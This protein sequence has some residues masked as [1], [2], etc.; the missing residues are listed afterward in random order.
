[1][2][3]DIFQLVLRI[4]FLLLG[5]VLIL[6]IWTH[7]VRLH[8][9]N[10]YA[11]AILRLSNWLVQPIRRLV[12]QGRWADWPALLACWLT[13]LVYMMTSWLVLTGN[14]PPLSWLMGMLPVAVLTVLEW[15]FNVVLWLT[16][17]QAILS[18]VNPMAPIMPVVQVLTAPLLDPI[19]RVLPRLGGI[20]FSPLVLLILAQIM[21]RV[22]QRLV[23]TLAGV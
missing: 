6:R 8:P 2:F 17:I 10:P 19:R 4:G 22:L 12:P 11:Q 23:Y 20:D 3:S 1:M 21:M 9:F 15:T 18:W 5:T 16:L 13:A 14:F 7:A